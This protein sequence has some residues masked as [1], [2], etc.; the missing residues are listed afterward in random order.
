MKKRGQCLG[1]Q[2]V[3]INESQRCKFLQWPNP[4]QQPSVIFLQ[5]DISSSWSLQ[6]ISNMTG[7]RTQNDN[8][9]TAALLVYW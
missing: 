5:K 9:I 4:L 7:Q 2:I 1:S 6:H 3:T 8:L